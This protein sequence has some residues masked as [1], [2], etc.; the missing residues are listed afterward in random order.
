[1][2]DDQSVL[3]FGRLTIDRF[4]LK[5]PIAGPLVKQLAIAQVTRERKVKKPDDDDRKPVMHKQRGRG[6]D[7]GIARGNSVTEVPVGAK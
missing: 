7:E 3:A 1:M 5:L 2:P 4:L 6:S